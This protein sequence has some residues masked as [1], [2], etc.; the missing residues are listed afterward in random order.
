MEITAITGY[1]LRDLHAILDAHY[2]ALDR[3]IVAR[4]QF[5][6]LERGTKVP[7]WTLPQP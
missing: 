1:S 2:L 3:A 7:N 4:I 5:E 6:R